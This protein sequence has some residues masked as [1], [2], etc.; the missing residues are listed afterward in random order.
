LVDKCS[1]KSRAVRS[2]ILTIRPDVKLVGDPWHPKHDAG[3]VVLEERRRRFVLRLPG[4]K[5]CSV[6]RKGNGTAVAGKENG[7]EVLPGEYVL[8]W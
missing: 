5:L 4:L 7:F 3:A 6:M 8:S 2:G 1:V